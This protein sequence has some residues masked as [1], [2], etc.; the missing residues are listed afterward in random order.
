MISVRGRPLSLAQ[1][2]RVAHD[3]EPVEVAADAYPA[4][5]A[6]RRVV[7]QIVA[8]REVI[9]GVSTGFGKLSAHRCPAGG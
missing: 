9:Y 2:A 5:H 7:E 8:R 6:S 3:R 4:I 1:I